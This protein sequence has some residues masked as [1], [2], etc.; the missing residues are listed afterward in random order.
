MNNINGTVVIQSTIA[1]IIALSFTE[2]MRE[3]SHYHGNG[4]LMKAIILRIFVI[5]AIMLAAFMIAGYL[6]DEQKI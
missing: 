2:V 1:S 4:S 5:V 3:M 6:D